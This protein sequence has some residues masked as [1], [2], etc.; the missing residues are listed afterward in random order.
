MD[1]TLAELQ[2]ATVPYPATLTLRTGTATGAL[3]FL[4]EVCTAGVYE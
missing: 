2:D 1:S 4:C 3:L